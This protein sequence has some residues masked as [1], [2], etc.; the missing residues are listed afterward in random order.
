ME[1]LRFAFIPGA[2]VFAVLALISGPRALYQRTSRQIYQ[3]IRS[4]GPPRY[5]RRHG[6]Y[7]VLAVACAVGI[8]LTS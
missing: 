8:Y 2:L 6:L 3:R 5:G 4:D 7:A 1:I